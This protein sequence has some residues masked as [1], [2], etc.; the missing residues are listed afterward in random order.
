MGGRRR[1]ARG[2]VRWYKTGVVKFIPWLE[3]KGII[4]ERMEL[5]QGYAYCHMFGVLAVKRKWLKDGIRN[6]GSVEKL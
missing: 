1:T 5:I 6:P 3:Q 2:G 4:T